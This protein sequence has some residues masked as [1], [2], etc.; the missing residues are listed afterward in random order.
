[1]SHVDALLALL[2]V[3][4]A[5]QGWQRGLCREGFALAG[6]VGGLIAAVAVAPP[7]ADRLS[8]AGASDLV[9]FPI[10][11]VAV[12]VATM[13]IARLAGVFVG[14]AL[15]AVFLGG[16]DRFAGVAFGALKGA[17]C[18]GLVLILLER[19]V[20]STSMQIAIEGSMLGPPL[21]RVATSVLEVGRGL[22]TMA[23]QV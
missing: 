4:F 5:L 13:L 22:S 10:A 17:A 16:L 23:S 12:V 6:V 21:M 19:F 18:L 2:L 1:M 8:A 15:H 9:A 20:P 3:P 11:L 14:R 7:V